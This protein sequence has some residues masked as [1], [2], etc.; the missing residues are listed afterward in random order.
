MT[1][2]ERLIEPKSIDIK[3]LVLPNDQS[4][5]TFNPEIDIKDEHWQEIYEVIASRRN[6]PNY[7]P[8]LSEY[9]YYVKI[10]SPQRFNDLRI[11]SYRYNTEAKS[12]THEKEEAKSNPYYRPVYYQDHYR[13]DIRIKILKPKVKRASLNILDED[14]QGRL[15]QIRKQSPEHDRVHM[16]DDYW[17]WTKLFF[18]QEFRKNFKESDFKLLKQDLMKWRN[19]ENETH[20]LSQTRTLRL[21]A[22]ER[23]QEFKPDYSQWKKMKEY[24]FSFSSPISTIFENAANLTI[25]AAD[26]VSLDEDGLRITMN[27]FN[28]D[29]QIPALPHIRRFA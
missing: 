9:L 21:L 22:P 15:N 12:I 7:I 4:E 25:I 16:I 11:S 10:I 2:T 24:Y 13:R 20:D 5:I 8:S 27:K 6:K 19:Q 3:K 14:L 17:L 23:Y 18:P 26:E 29:T 1:A 28:K